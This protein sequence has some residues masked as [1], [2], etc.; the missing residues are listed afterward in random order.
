MSKVNIKH[1]K[2]RLMARRVLEK[3]TAPIY[4][5]ELEDPAKFCSVKKYEKYA[6][7][8]PDQTNNVRHISNVI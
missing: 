2:P 8:S 6:A 4:P 3:I 7:M 5:L 1:P